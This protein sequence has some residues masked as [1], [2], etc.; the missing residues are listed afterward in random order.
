ML[1]ILMMSAKIFTAGF[2]IIR[3][4]W[5]NSYDVIIF[6]HDVTNKT[7]SD[8]SNYI[9]DVVMWPK[10]GNCDFYEK[11]CHN[12][13]GFDQKGKG[14]S[15]FKIN[16]LGLVL[17]KNLKFCTSAAKGLK[18][19]VR[20]FWGSNSTFVEVTVE[21]LVGGLFDTAS[22]PSRIGLKWHV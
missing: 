8:D 4:F 10:F 17:A 6:V 3:L 21:K 14:W 5:N 16:N 13:K 12:L 7:L 15:W 2:R 19:K 18:L 22:P 1:T 9:M 11:S 20:K